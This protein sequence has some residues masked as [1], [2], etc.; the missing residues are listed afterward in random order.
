MQF[1]HLLTLCFFALSCLLVQ[2]AFAQNKTITGKVTD[3]K[4]GQPLIGV[5]V[6]TAGGA[7]TLTATDGTF[8]L[9]V[10]ANTTSLVLSYI[11]YNR[12]TV[13][14][15]G[16]TSIDVSM[17]SASTNLN[18]VVVIGYGTQ[19]VKDATGSVSSLGQKDFNKGVIATPDQLLQGRVAGVQ[20]TP[21]S[22]EPGAGAQINIR[23][24]GS[25]RSG[26]GPLYVVDGIPL[27][28]GG[29]SGGYGVGAGSSSARNPLAFL[30]PADIEN[31]SILKDASSAAIYGARGA[32]GVILITTRKGR[33]GQGVQFSS[34]VSLANPASR[35]DVLGRDQFLAAVAA[36]GANAGPVS[37]GGVDYG[38]D[39]DWQK[40]I[41]RTAISQNYNVGFGG[42]GNTASYRASIGYD[43][44]K[45]IIKNTGLKRLNAR[46]N[47]SKSFFNERLKF[48][49]QSTYS[50]VKNQYA[51]ITNN[52]GFNGSLV[53]AAIQLNPTAPVFD[54]QGRYFNLN[55]YN[56]DGYPNGN[57]FRNPVSLLDHIDDR[58]NI[59]RYLNNLTMTVKLL[60]GLSY[61]GNFGADISRGLRKTFYDPKIVGFT[62][63]IGI[64]Q[65]NYPSP[66]GNG[67][68]IYQNNKLTNYTTEH[69]LNYDKK[70]KDNSSLTVLAGYSYQT[71]KN[72]NDNQFGFKT[73]Q[74]GVLVKDYNDFQ[75]HLPVP[76]GDSSSYK[77][78]SYFA[79]VNYSIKDR[80][81]ITGTIRR[82]GSSRFGA[83]HKY[84]NFP[85][86]AVK[87]RIS[88][89]EFMPKGGFFDDLSLRINWGK[90]GNQEIPAYAS[91]PV[92]QIINNSGGT[93]YLYQP[94]PDLKWQTNTTY[95]AGIDFS[96]IKGRL[97]GTVDYF[98]KS[99]QDLL[100]F[101][102]IA[103]PTLSSRIYRNLD[104]N[105]INKGLE[106]GLNFAAVQGKDFSWDI[107][108]NMTFIKNT[109]SNFKNYIITGNIDGQGLSGAFSQLIT[110][111]VP[112]FTFNVPNYAGLDA[113]GFGIYP[114]GLDVSSLQGSP[115]P[116]FTAG[117]TNNF[118]YKNWNL[119]FFL[120]AATGFYIYN[121]TANAFFFKGNLLSGRNVTKDVATSNEN[122]LNSGE[123]S[124]RFLEKGDFLRLSNATLG[125]TFPL[126]ESVFKSLRLS[127]TGQNLFLITNYSGLDPEINTDKQRDQVASRGIDYTAY[128]KARIFTL[129]LNASF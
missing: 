74:P 32:N 27:D 17:E 50:N 81:I 124:T 72:F 96:I 36:V 113:N 59:N 129:G 108:Y 76:V 25:I 118:T 44:Q 45:G 128:P 70:W 34:N 29:T 82:D 2:P 115:N 114:N 85:A 61:K 91:L 62:D 110:N 55:G 39:T 18:E 122:P 111:G 121:N 123:V 33:K 30:N 31:I 38:G 107:N 100:F 68:A 51:L 127:V 102:D 90:T 3:K 83:N 10:P 6:G 78:Q 47:A 60:E 116:K 101:Q 94:N 11:G 54:D 52:A 65:V 37:A 57:G 4:D 67:T 13:S 106:V 126:K 8:R 119:S 79:R 14:I 88:N 105:V 19:R 63:A 42:A 1:K 80:Y 49:L 40:Q 103:Q 26:D 56:A 112:L 84:G 86:A 53:G 99:I 117:L 41:Y 16:R 24:A 66:T 21:S 12:L 71:F 48:D 15:D 5:S 89:E 104:G 87:W 93:A 23:G 28:N 109:L 43:D 120:N 77:L 20:V 9:S 69:T 58:D 64:R 75:Q 35:Y 7:G 98:N 73:S 92:Q 95:G 46:I 97:T 22:G 125:Y